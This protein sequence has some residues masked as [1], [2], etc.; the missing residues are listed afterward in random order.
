[1]TAVLLP[2]RLPVA[3]EVG[4]AA[5]VLVLVLLVM[6]TVVRRRRGAQPGWPSRRSQLRKWPSRRDQLRRRPGRKGE[7]RHLPVGK[8]V[9]AQYKAPRLGT[10]HVP[11]GTPDGSPG[12][13]QRAHPGGT[14]S[15]TGRAGPKI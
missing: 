4:A 15:G 3:D 12:L 8:P 14:A 1:M 13:R 2:H 5:V 11:P 10:L 7:V 6:G 9:P